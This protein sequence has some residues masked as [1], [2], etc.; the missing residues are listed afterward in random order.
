MNYDDKHCC[1]ILVFPFLAGY[2][3]T[4][5][6]WVGL[7]TIWTNSEFPS[8][9]QSEVTDSRFSGY[10]YITGLQCSLIFFWVPMCKCIV[11]SP[12]WHTF[13]QE[14][15][16]DPEKRPSFKMHSHW[17]TSISQNTEYS[18]IAEPSTM[19]VA[20]SLT[21]HFALCSFFGPAYIWINWP[22]CE[23]S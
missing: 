7:P 8:W 4:V 17:L 23:H 13:L 6:W 22:N 10:T 3:Y 11:C 15:D 1:I 18:T 20:S 5:L 21:S 14:L 9:E 2:L 19:N 16:S 12:F